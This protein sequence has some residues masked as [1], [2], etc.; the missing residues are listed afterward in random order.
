MPQ[1][2][3]HPTRKHQPTSRA[4][5]ASRASRVKARNHTRR[6]TQRPHRTLYRPRHRTYR[7]RHIQHTRRSKGTRKRPRRKQ[8][9]GEDYVGELIT[10]NNTHGK[11]ADTTFIGIAKQLEN[12]PDAE[13]WL[14]WINYMMGEITGKHSV[15]E[16]TGNFEVVEEKNKIRKEQLNESIRQYVTKYRDALHTK[17]TDWQNFWH[18]W[19][20]PTAHDKEVQ[21]SQNR[22][23]DDCLV[24][25][26]FA[27]PFYKL[28][29]ER[30]I[31]LA[32]E[33]IQSIQN[34][35][36]ALKTQGTDALRQAHEDKNMKA[37]TTDDLR[38]QLTEH[39]TKLTDAGG[40]ILEA[41]QKIETASANLA[42]LNH[43]ERTQGGLE[44]AV[45][46]TEKVHP[47]K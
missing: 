31:V 32:K 4:S 36:P 29:E 16:K 45:N 34:T 24:K 14:S 2:L 27:L 5:R 40:K 11:I 17:D 25:D 15:K 38:R 3:S 47:T 43:L 12:I 13:S 39:C 23:F 41:Q 35:F 20:V 42:M 9:G 28:Y 21:R 7:T 22:V 30:E 1:P 8:C 37:T 44:G 26:L 19:N 10:F 6:Q 46:G 18:Y 33:E